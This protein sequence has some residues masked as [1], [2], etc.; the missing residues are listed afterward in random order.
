MTAVTLGLYEPTF[1]FKK[2]FWSSYYWARQSQWF[3]RCKVNKSPC[4]PKA[5]NFSGWRPKLNKPFHYS[6][7]YWDMW[8]LFSCW[9]MSDAFVTPSLPSVDSSTPSSSIHGISQARILEWVAIPFSRGS[10]W[11]RDQTQVSCI[12][13]GFFTI[14]ATREAS[15]NVVE[16]IERS[17]K[18]LWGLFKPF[19]NPK[20]MNEEVSNPFFS[21][22]P[23]PVLVVDILTIINNVCLL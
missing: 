16:A 5:G 23:K 14:W 6:M 7:A 20:K 9:V 8:L 17:N 15:L 1:S 22:S 21:T 10:S 4:S 3:Q 13:G 18:V 11:P 19:K 2:Y 12:A